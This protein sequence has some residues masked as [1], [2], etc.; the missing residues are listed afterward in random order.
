[1]ELH[2]CKCEKCKQVYKDIDPSY[3]QKTFLVPNARELQ[4][5]LSPM[6]I[7]IFICPKCS[8]GEYLKEV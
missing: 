4:L 8:S 1:M 7:P 6:N 5:I 3:G 2:L